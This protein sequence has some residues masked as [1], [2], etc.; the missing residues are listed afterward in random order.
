MGPK[1]TRTTTT[2]TTTT[3]KRKTPPSNSTARK[4][5]RTYDARTLAVQS[6]DAAL[7]K[8]GE[9]DVSAF[10]AAREFEIRA[11]EAGIRNSKAA[12]ASRAFQQVP[13][14]LRR[15]TASHNVKR[16]PSR[17]RARA[18]REMIEDNTP[19]VTARRRKPTKL[20]RLRLETARR[21]QNLNARSKARRALKK[22]A[23]S[24]QAP[25]IAMEVEGDAGAEGAK[26]KPPHD[27]NIAPRVPKIKKNRLSHPERPQSKFKKRQRC[28][29]WLPTHMFHAKRAHMTSPKE[30]LWRFAVP[31]SPTEKSY[32]PTHRASGARGAV[33]WDMSYIST[34]GLEGVEGSLEGLFR[35]LGVGGEEAWGNKGRK[36]RAGTRSLEVWLFE[37][38]GE[39]GGGGW[40]RPIAPVTLIWCVEKTDGD[41]NIEMVDAGRKAKKPRRKMFLRVHPSAFLQVWEELLKAAKLQ[42]Q[43]V[44]VE[45][46]RFDIGSIEITG[47]GATETLLAALQPIPLSDGKKWPEGSPEATWASLAGLTNAAS[48]PQNALLAFNISDPR[49]RHPPLTVKPPAS[50]SYLSEL[51][52]LLSTWNPDSTQLKP[53]IFSRPARLTASRLLPSQKAINRRKSLAN[54]GEY[55]SPKPSDPDIPVLVIAS[56]PKSISKGGN[57]Q[58]TYTVLLPWKC[59]VPV[60]Y[61]IMYYPLSSGGNPRFGGLLEQQQLAF[62]CGEPW[63][64]GDYPGTNAGWAWEM[65]EREIRR[66][67]W[68]RKPKQKRVAYDSIDLGGG[69][70]GEIGQ[71]W[72]CDWER[73]VRPITPKSEEVKAKTEAT[74]T[75]SETEE[76][77]QE[78]EKQETGVCDGEA[79]GKQ[80]KHK[81]TSSS[82]ACTYVHT[83]PPPPPLHIHQLPHPTASTILRIKTTK[84]PTAKLPTPFQ[85]L[86]THPALATVSL[87]LLNRGTPTPRARLYRLPTTNPSLRNEW[88]ALLGPSAPTPSSQKQ[89]KKQKQ[90]P[91]AAA[92]LAQDSSR[93]L[94]TNLSADPEPAAHLPMPGEEDLIGF[95]TTG[96]YNLAAGRG[97]GVASILVE[98]VGVY[99]GSDVEK[100]GGSSSEESGGSGDGDGIARAKGN[101]KGGGFSQEYLA[102]VCIIRSAGER[103]G[104]LG[105]WE[106]V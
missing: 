28:K 51:A 4:R 17:L 37:R 54:P 46:L 102:R 77:T 61:S 67:E 86:L 32:R 35:A 81:S 10:V 27:I 62:E 63:F 1:K 2:T 56:R 95:V 43:Q 18:R 96:N 106:V 68:E 89:S 25:A 103:V 87:T 36:W 3:K 16:V 94:P 58:G 48:L 90:K 83:K 57:S 99:D 41:G 53:D 6:S 15:R 65:R 30:P 42:S 76:Q 66:G 84:K 40:K 74:A 5:A 38:D 52:V 31:L 9:L 33:A 50:E 11:L 78:A 24:A 97:T 104:R 72:S 98:R 12:L 39:G 79:K 22:A 26:T 69:K 105:V 13:R 59:V 14:N 73:L 60:W 75:V 93:Q 19:T 71:G 70:K 88:L 101:G 21:L 29:T 45:D 85:S 8:T 92:A 44:M 7:S 47:P 100:L 64:P 82:T 55:P 23:V 91:Q 80:R 20:L 34:I 49:L